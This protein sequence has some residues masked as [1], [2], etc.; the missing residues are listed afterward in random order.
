[1]SNPSGSLK[2]K[3]NGELNDLEIRMIERLEKTTKELKKIMTPIE[4][5]PGFVQG[6]L[7]E[8]NFDKVSDMIDSLNNVLLTLDHFEATDLKNKVLQKLE[9]LIDSIE[10]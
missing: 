4:V 7:V 9:L 3:R 5:Q 10:V 1:M 8:A 2:K 6:E